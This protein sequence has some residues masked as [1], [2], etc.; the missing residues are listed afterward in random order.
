[1]LH[2][3]SAPPFVSSCQP[4]I[5]P[6]SNPSGKRAIANI[7]G[8]AAVEKSRLPS[9]N[10]NRR[11][12]PMLTALRNL[13]VHRRT[14]KNVLSCCLGANIAHPNFKVTGPSLGYSGGPHHHFSL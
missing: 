6:A 12:V 10:M 2:T 14:N 1:M 13:V 9:P 8:H 3:A 7:S 4:S 11:I 5:K